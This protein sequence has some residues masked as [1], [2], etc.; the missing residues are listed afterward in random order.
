MEERAALNFGPYLLAHR[1]PV[2]YRFLCRRQE[3][4]AGLLESL[5]KKRAEGGLSPAAEKRYSEIKEEMR[6][7]ATA[8][9]RYEK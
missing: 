4:L 8:Q 3:V 9:K 2:L 6:L 5:S 1:N 7:I